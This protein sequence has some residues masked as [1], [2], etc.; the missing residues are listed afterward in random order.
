MA[1]TE[2]DSGLGRMDLSEEV[3]AVCLG[4]KVPQSPFLN[5][6]RIQR[7]EAA[8][9]EGQEIK[10]ALHVVQESDR[11][12]EVGA[13]IGVVSGVVA[14]NAKP[15]KVLSFEANP[16]LVPTIQML[17][18]INGLE[19]R[20]ELRNQVL[21]AGEGRPETMPFY[22][23]ESYLGSSLIERKGRSAQTVDV[24]TVA[25]EEVIAELNPTV[26][27]M[28]IEGGE[29]ALLEVMP[30]DPFRAIVIEFHP[31]AYEIAGM[32]R[33]KTILREA[34]FQKVEEVSTRNVWTCVRGEGATP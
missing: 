28:D 14:L 19:G 31:G 10:G 15:E 16:A 17:H 12:L 3:A 29:L 33:C 21:Y 24:P 5:A 8:R 32:R 20:V 9:Y 11:V 2:Q 6:N 30:L 26:L 25:M 4:L 7:I 1:E 22:V 34:G 23:H 18:K 27:I 13:G